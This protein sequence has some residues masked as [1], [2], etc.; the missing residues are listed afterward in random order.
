MSTERNFAMSILK[1]TKKGPISIEDVKN[2]SRLPSVITERLLE[3]LQNENIIKLESSC[4]EVDRHD[5]LKL[6]VKATLLG[7]DIECVS[8][9]LC[10]QE[11]EAI[12][13]LALKNNGY[14]VTSNY[15]FT[16]AGRKWEIDAIGCKKP[17]VVCIDCK[18]WQRGLRHSVLKRIVDSQV[19]RTS[20]LAESVPKISSKMEYAQWD[21]A[22]FVPAILSL[23][24]CSS[25]FYD[26]VP[27]VPILQ[28][29]DFLYQLPACTGYLKVLPKIHKKLSYE[30]N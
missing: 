17:I 6:A 24:P 20:A 25:K 7:A 2:D 28:L 5:R 9:L 1:L 21:N 13:T 3:E 12:A 27:I 18:H 19:K 30:K 14:T 23:I 4:I 15:H 29:Q 22:I 11:F 10:W 16:Y 8:S 26:K